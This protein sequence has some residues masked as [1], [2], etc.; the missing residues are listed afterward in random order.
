MNSISSGGDFEFNVI[1]PYRR[2]VLKNG[3]KLIADQFNSNAISI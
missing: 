1:E 3:V 2:R